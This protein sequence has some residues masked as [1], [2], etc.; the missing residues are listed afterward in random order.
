MEIDLH[1]KPGR[2]EIRMLMSDK[3]APIQVEYQSLSLRIEEIKKENHKINEKMDRLLVICGK[4]AH[5]K[6]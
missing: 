5:D 2:A 6:D 3:L 1:K 4:L